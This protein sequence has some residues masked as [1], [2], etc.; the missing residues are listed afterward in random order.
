M[1][2]S[3]LSLMITSA[4]LTGCGG[5]SGDDSSATAS[6]KGVAIDGYITGATAFLDLNFNGKHDSGEPSAITGE[7]GA[8][9]LGLTGSDANCADYAPVII[10]VPVG[11][12][13][14]DHGDVTEAYQLSFPPAFAAASEEEI[15]ST[16]PLTTV[17]W[18]SIEAELNAADKAPTCAALKANYDMRNEIKNRVK[19]QE[20]RVAQRYNVAV[21]KLYSDFI[22]DKDYDL[23]KLAQD[24][25]PSLQKSYDDTRT[26]QKNNTNAAYAYVEY[27]WGLWDKTAENHDDKWYRTEYVNTGDAYTMVTHEVDE[28]LEKQVKLIE[29]IERKGKE[30][31]AIQYERVTSAHYNEKGTNFD[32]SINEFYEQKTQIS[33][34]VENRSFKAVDDWNACKSMNPVDTLNTQAAIT[35]VYSENGDQLLTDSRHDYKKGDVSVFDMTGL[36]GLGDNIESLDGDKLNVVDTILTDFKDKSGYGASSWIRIKHEFPQ[37][38]EQI[39]TSHDQDGLWIVRH[40]LPNGTWTIKC[41]AEGDLKFVEKREQ[42]PNLSEE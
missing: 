3:I 17:V 2:K 20:L 18:E 33:Y 5:G 9:D 6:L 12:V 14:S 28:T 22:E 39:S 4:I 38:G 36:I 26:L 15:R 10:D 16:T 8:Y 25:V 7:N 32:C 34:G 11:A 23:H 19:E 31:A 27:F 30:T 41:G 21:A 13:D 40:G 29:R 24:I 1:K 37:E 35:K 42:C